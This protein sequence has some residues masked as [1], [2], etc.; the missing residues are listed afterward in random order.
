MTGP[1]AI[2]ANA[3][4]AM[5]IVSAALEYNRK[6]GK[7]CRSGFQSRHGRVK[8]S[9]ALRRGWKPLLH[10][11]RNDDQGRISS[12]P[13]NEI[14]ELAPAISVGALVFLVL[15]PGDSWARIAHPA[16]LTPASRASLACTGGA[17]APGI[18]W[19]RASREAGSVSA[20]FLH[21]RFHIPWTWCRGPSSRT[22][23]RFPCCRLW[24]RS[25]TCRCWW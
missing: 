4:S 5:I 21:R 11:G 16:F 13:P 18:S 25:R 19:E 23:F 8:D 14:N 2:S 17:R 1:N 3:L 6:R 9:G 22:S 7:N 12:S 15:V 10:G 20:P 24:C